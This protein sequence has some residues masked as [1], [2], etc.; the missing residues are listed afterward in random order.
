MLNTLSDNGQLTIKKK[1]ISQGTAY[2]QIK[3]LLSEE[4]KRKT[5]HRILYMHKTI[6]HYCNR[7]KKN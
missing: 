6:V 1:Q 3:C 2:P 7:S 5:R 4:N